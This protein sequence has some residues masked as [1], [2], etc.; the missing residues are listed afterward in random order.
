MSLLYLTTVRFYRLSPT[1]AATL[2]LSALFY[3][4]ATVLSAARYYLGRGAQWKGRSQV[5]LPG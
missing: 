2:P 3:S 4:Y 1:W 5:K